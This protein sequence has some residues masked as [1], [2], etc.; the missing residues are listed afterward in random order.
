LSVTALNWRA[1]SASIVLIALIVL[2]AIYTIGLSVLWAQGF[3]PTERIQFLWTFGF[4]LILSLWVRA[5]RHARSF[6]TPYDFDA[7]VFFAWVIVV[8][9]YLCR[10]RGA[11]GLLVAAGI[12]AL[13]MAP[14]IAAQFV[15]LA[16][17][18]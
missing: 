5:D 6:S 10:T 18:R 14:S 9:Y 4:Q 2:T 15:R 17:S 1:G 8:P 16:L 11:R 12:F 13:L 3:G 7:F